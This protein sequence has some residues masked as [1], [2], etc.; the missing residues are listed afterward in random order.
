MIF[1]SLHINREKTVEQYE[2]P[3]RPGCRPAIPKFFGQR[4]RLL[5]VRLALVWVIERRMRYI[6]CPQSK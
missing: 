2:V 4:Q 1:C 6:Y 5:C 3:M